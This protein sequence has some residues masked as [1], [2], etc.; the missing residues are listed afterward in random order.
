MLFPEHSAA[1]G[2]PTDLMPIFLSGEKRQAVRTSTLIPPVKMVKRVN[3]ECNSVQ[4]RNYLYVISHLYNTTE[5]TPS[6]SKYS[7]DLGEDLDDAAVALLIEHGLGSRFPTACAAWKSRNAKSKET[8]WRG[9]SE[10]KRRI[11]EQL[12]NDRSLL[13]D[14]LARE[15]TRRILDAY[16]YVSLSKFHP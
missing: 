14:T 3:E 6:S 8:S 2:Y 7:I 15:I 1:G 10:E 4:L 5:L 12:K 16:P 11:D 13:E 9:V